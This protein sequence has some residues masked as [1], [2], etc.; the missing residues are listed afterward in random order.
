MYVL[1]RLSL[2]LSLTFNACY[3]VK[4]LAMSPW[5]PDKIMNFKPRIFLKTKDIYPL[6]HKILMSCANCTN[7]NIFPSTS[8]EGYKKPS[9]V[10]IPN[11]LSWQPRKKE[12]FTWQ[13]SINW[14]TPTLILIC[15]TSFTARYLFIVIAKYILNPPNSFGN[16]KE[17][18]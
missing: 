7:F 17:N 10:Q 16:E 18:S 12:K 8:E 11:P 4:L 1:K 15:P 5:V 3:F 2:S 6:F 14:L 13:T 9:N